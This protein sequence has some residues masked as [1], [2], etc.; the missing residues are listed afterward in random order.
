VSAT[1]TLIERYGRSTPSM[2]RRGRSWYPEAHR[3]LSRMAAEHD[4]TTAQAAAV[5]AITSMNTTLLS[6]IRFTEQILRGERTAGC[7]PAFQ[8]PLVISALKADRPGRFVRGPKC[9]A[10]YRAIM[11][12]VDALVL[13][14]WAARAAGHEKRW[15]AG[16]LRTELEHAYK[17]AAE[18]CGETV[19]AF[20][21]IVWIHTRETTPDVRGVVPNLLDITK[22]GRFSGS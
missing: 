22:S 4:R 7:Y 13:D 2:R 14:R 19:R 17:E 5:F 16:R 12:D 10:F 9:I 8:G 3:L 21:A 1:Q 6:N 18:A 15:V 20:Q 11:G